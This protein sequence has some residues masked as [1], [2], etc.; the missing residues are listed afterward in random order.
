MLL[1]NRRKREILFI[2]SIIVITIFKWTS[3]I[4]AALR[5]SRTAAAAAV[6]TASYLLGFKLRH[7]RIQWII[8]ALIEIHW[9]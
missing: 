5:H 4:A 8:Q 9:N 1:E 3:L 6:A 2:D 7:K